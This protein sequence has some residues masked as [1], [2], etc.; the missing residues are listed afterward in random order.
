MHRSVRLY[1]LCWLCWVSTHA[2]AQELYLKFPVTQEGMY[3]IPLELLRQQ[4]LQQVSELGIFGHH[5]PLPQQITEN[6][7]EIQQIQ[8][9]ILGN[10]LV[11]YAQGPHRI[12]ASQSSLHLETNPY[13]DTLYYWVGKTS[14]P[15]RIETASLA[16]PSLPQLSQ[17]SSIQFRNWQEDNILNSGR[18]WYSRPFFGGQT[19]QFSMPLTSALGNNHQLFIQYLGQAT[20]ENRF[21]ISIAGQNF[22]TFT[23]P[24]IPNSTFGIKGIEGNFQ[25]AVTFAGSDLQVRTRYESPDFNGAGYINFVILSSQLPVINLSNGIYMNRGAL[26]RIIPP[27]GNHVFWKISATNEVSLIQQPTAVQ[28]FE[29]IARFQENQI[30]T[31]RTLQ[32]VELS[33]RTTHQQAE[34]II[35]T[36][37]LLLNQANRLAQHK[38][39]RGLSTSVALIEDI[40]DGYAYGNRD[41]SGIRNFIADKFHSNGKLKNVLFLGKGTYDY[42]GIFQGRP[43]LVPT[44]TSRNSLNPLTTYSSDDFFGILAIGKGEWEESTN[45]DTPMQIGV[46]RIPAIN[47][48]EARE[49]VNK[50]IAYENT[51]LSLG[52]WKQQLAF[53]ADDGDNNIHLTDSENHIRYLE[54]NHPEFAIQKIYLDRFEQTRDASNRQ[55]SSAAQD[56]FRES[57]EKG[58]LFLNFIGHGNESTLTAE[59]IFII[60]QLNDWSRHDHFPLII[61]A[62][63]EFGRHDSPLLRSA[64]EELLFAEGKGAIGLL[65]TGRPVF[66]SI[67]FRL[68]SAFIQ[69]VFKKDDGDW[70]DLGTIFKLTKNNSL[71]GTL[72]RNFSLLGDPSLRLALPELKSQTEQILDLKLETEVTKLAAGQQVRIK[73]SIEDP[74]TGAVLASQS[75]VFKLQVFDRPVEF[76]TLGDENP[77]ITIQ[78]RSNLLFQGGGQ[79]VAGRFQSEVFIPLHMDAT[80]A[81]GAIQVFATLTNEMEAFGV[82]PI[83]LGGRIQNSTDTTG[84]KITLKYGLE[85]D[86]QQRIFE[87]AFIP[88]LIELEDESG[89]NVLFTQPEKNI[90]LQVNDGIPLVLNSTFTATGNQFR[91][92]QIRTALRGLRDGINTIRVAAWDNVGNQSISEQQIEVKNTNQLKI[93][94]LVNYPNPASAQS[95]FKIVQN[96]PGENILLKLRVYSLLGQEIFTEE[97]RYIRADFILDDL[98]WNFFQTETKFPAKGTYIYTLQLSSELDGSSDSKSGKILI[99]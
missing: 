86:V 77:P 43:N 25:R 84:P 57:I 13:S 72:N 62:T 6:F 79:V 4:G 67:N 32:R 33:T 26:G 55:R 8:S 68:N 73:G 22:E 12:V 65:T 27:G 94:T 3:A 97:K 46:G 24:P 64:A 93:L 1:F 37:P 59:E 60:S 88:L 11:F 34:L 61:T 38:Q 7:N 90:V 76:T 91:Q 85:E 40:F 99:R 87:T 95:K 52:S 83:K 69:A 31:I 47:P 49:A 29:K 51:S 30:P 80:E 23:I 35:I 74:L 21:Q 41:V 44:Y 14:Q 50:I 78:E 45:G 58:V 89:I 48:R 98:E 5:G 82:T 36:H 2:N 39:A 42:K 81:M 19:F 71:N 53:V 9:Q 75:G 16:D 18:S 56:A 70:R 28:P 92:G 66:S 63:C 17:L 20:A 96:R 54:K 10:S 15:K